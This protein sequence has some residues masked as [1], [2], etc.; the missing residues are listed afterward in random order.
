MTAYST[1][2]TPT[3]PFTT[4]VDTDGAVLASGWTAAVDELVS[5]ISP[6][7]RPAEVTERPDLGAV[8]DAVRAFH[9]GDL[10][11]VEN[12][13]VRQRGGAFIEQ[14]W[15][16][17]RTVPAGK[18]VSYAELADLAGRP[19]AV[20]AAA[21]ACARNPAALFVPCHRVVRTG[22]GLGGFRWGPGVKEWLL[23]HETG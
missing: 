14:V 7:L 18:Q 22:G 10:H 5:G 1:V 2:D 8:T 23:R 4:I 21:S 11:A 12:I 17:L 20:R 13:E 6:A 3:G 15:K 19:S 9:E 16:V